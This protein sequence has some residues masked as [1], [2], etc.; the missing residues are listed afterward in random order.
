MI[1]VLMVEGCTPIQSHVED[2][3][4]VKKMLLTY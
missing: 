2:K 4:T 3:V 1:L